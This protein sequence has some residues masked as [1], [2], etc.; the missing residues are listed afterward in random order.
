MFKFFPV[1]NISKLPAP[2]GDYGKIKLHPVV[3][4]FESPTKQQ[5]VKT[6]YPISFEQLGQRYGFVA[7]HT[8]VGNVP[9]MDPSVLQVNVRDRAIVFLNNVR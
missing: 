4:L 6:E 5:I 2:K 3:S 1:L 7:Y 8:T 9:T